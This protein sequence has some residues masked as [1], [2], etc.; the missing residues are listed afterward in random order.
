LDIKTRVIAVLL[1]V[2]VMTFV[3]RG[4][5]VAAQEQAAPSITMR[6][7]TPPGTTA[8]APPPSWL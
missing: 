4:S 7:D 2:A 6:S 8:P 1:A 3:I 5:A